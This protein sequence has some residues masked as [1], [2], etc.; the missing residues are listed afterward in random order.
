MCCLRVPL[1]FDV[2]WVLWVFLGLVDFIMFN[3]LL[4]RCFWGLSVVVLV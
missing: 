2:L 4:V 3:V 1:G